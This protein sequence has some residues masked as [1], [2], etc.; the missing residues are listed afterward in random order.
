M[1]ASKTLRITT[2][3]SSA[4]GTAATGPPAAPEPGGDALLRV[5]TWNVHDAVGRDGQRDVTRV[6]R[7]IATLCAPIVGLQEV[8]CGPGDACDIEK[9]AHATGLA[10]RAVPT[11][12]PGPGGFQCGNALLTSLP[13]AGVT[14]HD[15]SIPGR[16]PPM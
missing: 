9:L 15:L 8:G 4:P 1:N 6:G 3:L 11:R 16:K 14:V 13:V 5:A 7:V 12:R 10:W 2:P